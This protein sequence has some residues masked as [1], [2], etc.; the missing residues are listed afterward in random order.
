MDDTINKDN[1]NNDLDGDKNDKPLEDGKSSEQT[2]LEP[3]STLPDNTH[4]EEIPV[5]E[6]AENISDDINLTE[7]SDKEIEITH[8]EE[9]QESKSEE[10][11]LSINT[12][13]STDEIPIEETEIILDTGFEQ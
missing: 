6:N 8:I 1:I 10:I 12:D 5:E 4:N 3:E 2:K 9:I 13:I 7:I 11:P